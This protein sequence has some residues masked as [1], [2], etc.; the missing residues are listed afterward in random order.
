MTSPIAAG[1]VVYAKDLPRV[2][3]FY[4]Q[5]LGLEIT[6]SEHDH[7]VLESQG[8]QLVV[9]AIPADIG[10]S[11]DIATPPL[12]REDA[13]VKLVFPVPSLGAA[14]VLA[15]K[16]GGALDPADREWPFQDSRVCD[17]HDPE[18]NVIQLREI[19]TLL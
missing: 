10:E 3:A 15:A 14:R 18:G 6:D 5:V 13:A 16:H 9:H 12:R 7:V 4:A 17:G 19:T 2:T 8:F 11:I 1:A